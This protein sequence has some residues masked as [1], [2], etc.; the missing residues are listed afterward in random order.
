VIISILLYV[1][2]N[3]GTLL[4]S[5]FGFLI[6]GLGLEK[7]A[8]FRIKRRY[9]ILMLAAFWSCRYFGLSLFFST[10]LAGI[11]SGQSWFESMLSLLMVFNVW[12]GI[13]VISLVYNGDLLKKL[14]LEMLFELTYAV[15]YV[16]GLYALSIGVSPDQLN[17][18]Y[19]EPYKILILSVYAILITFGI[20]RYGIPLAKR[21]MEREPGY[22]IAILM[23]LLVYYIAGSMNSISFA[24]SRGNT[25]S[26]MHIYAL[27]L[28]LS[29][30]WMSFFHTEKMKAMM[31]NYDLIRHEAALKSYYQQA[32]MQS[33]RIH[34]Y[35]IEI[36]EAI[37]TILEK[38]EKRAKEETD[39]L[40][41]EI[42]VRDYLN[43]LEQ[44]YSDLTVSKY[45]DDVRTNDLLMS[46]EDRFHQRQIPVQLRFHGFRKP[47]N[48]ADKDMDDLL[49]GLCDEILGHYDTDRSE[50]LGENNN[51]VILQGG[52]TVREMILSGQYPG[53]MPS[54]KA[55][56]KMKSE[57]RRL[58]ADISCIKES[59]AVK[60]IIGVPVRT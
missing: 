55:I 17:I 26:R 1:F 28:S 36:R 13:I 29:Y 42:F 41:T 24:I 15:L 11:Y 39:S 5:F 21:Y 53:A 56:R 49:H 48:L 8:G 35:N 10:Y 14:F 32:L 43:K 46:V 54:D 47:V 51:P 12:I 44:E 58:R 16:I 59:D 20:I 45:S 7:A 25:G 33:A 40:K 23:I 6:W 38:A 19:M 57:F 60:I 34:R 4:I 18:M 3:I 9:A 37:D 50:C 27:I 30:L 22:P 52:I 31:S 2:H